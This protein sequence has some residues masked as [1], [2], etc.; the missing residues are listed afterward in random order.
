VRRRLRRGTVIGYY[1]VDV[2]GNAEPPHV[3]TITR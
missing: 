2:F 1:S 3:V